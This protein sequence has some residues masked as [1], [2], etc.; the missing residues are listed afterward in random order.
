MNP[1]PT[2]LQQGG[3]KADLS[4]PTGHH[5]G[6]CSHR[7]VT[8]PPQHPPGMWHLLGWDL[9]VERAWPA[10]DKVRLTSWG[11]NLMSVDQWPLLSS[12][13]QCLAR[14]WPVPFSL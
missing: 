6:H 14:V 12:A 7:V 9:G 3:V 11:P 8:L 13:G 2:L 4:L 10:L 1:L 5:L